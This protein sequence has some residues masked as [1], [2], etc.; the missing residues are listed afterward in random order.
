[1]TE[2][3]FSKRRLLSVWL[4]D[5]ATD[6]IARRRPEV[7][8]VPTVVTLPENGR[9]AVVAVNRPGAVL[10][11]APGQGLSDARALYPGALAVEADPGGDAQAQA[12]LADW[13]TRYTPWAATDPAAG[14]FEGGLR[15][16]IAG[17]AHLFGGE[18]ALLED[19]GRRLAG[20]GL[21]HRL[22][23]APTLGAAWAWARFGDPGQPVLDVTRPGDLADRLAPLPVAA[24]RLPPADADML[25]RLGLRRVGDL[26]GIPRAAL[27]ARFGD[28]VRRRLDQA[29]GHESEPISPRRHRTPRAERFVAN[30]PLLQPEDVPRILDGLL[31]R[32]CRRL[33]A[34]GLGARRLVYTLYRVDGTT[35]EAQV[36][37]SRPTR[38]A[39]HLARLF[40]PRL[41]G[42]DPDPGVDAALLSAVAT[43]PFRPRQEQAATDGPTPGGPKPSHLS[44]HSPELAELIDRLAN[45]LGPDNVFQLAPA[46]RA[47]PEDRSVATPALDGAPP[48]WSAWPAT[49]Y[50]PPLRLLSSPSAVEAVEEDKGATGP[51]PPLRG[52]S[53]DAAFETLSADSE[54]VALPADES[55]PPARFHWRRQP[56]ELAA[57]TGPERVVGPWWAGD[58][59]WRDYWRAEDRDG[60][61]LWLFRD[62][63]TG[64]WH[65]HGLFG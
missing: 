11:L 52:R 58:A 46:E 18:A 45:R 28:G 40:A 56:V 21:A 6:R 26:Y 35:A 1:M 55:A 47:L 43:D 34:E 54:N 7:R 31:G 4:P 27:A 29:L 22:A 12:R 62:L 5:F 19:L 17:C 23:I 51:S 44:A 16:D 39:A 64:R 2:V 59:R 57:A 25:V 3:P 65:V 13:A 49:T 50:P 10:G 61:R 20:F 24:L 15:L 37:T 41:E 63:A 36:G 60:R 8:A 42:L 48:D 14:S 30:E 9:L 53:T 32:L 38:E 33:E